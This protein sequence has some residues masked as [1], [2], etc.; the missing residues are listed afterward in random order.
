MTLSS[1]AQH[2]PHSLGQAIERLSR[3]WGWV[4]AAGALIVAFGVFALALALSATIASVFLVGFFMLL[5]GLFEI[6]I[7]IASRRWSRFLLWIAA[8]LLYAVAGAAAIAEP[9]FAAIFFTLILGAGFVATGSLRLWIAFHLPARRARGLK[10]L[11]GMATIVLGLA[12]LVGW[13]GDS[14]FALGLLLGLEL[15]F[16]GAGW[17]G[18]GLILHAHRHHA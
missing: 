4:V 9:V 1:G 18:F 3:R 5:A 12:I 16:R 7:G 8:G 11:S 15:I 2:E 10:V 6:G 17:I 13:P 14:L